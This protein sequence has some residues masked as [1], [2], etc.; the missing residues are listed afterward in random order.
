MHEC[1]CI[2]CGE[3][4]CFF[5][6]C[7]EHHA[8]ECVYGRQVLWTSAYTFAYTLAT[9][10]ASA[11]VYMQLVH[12]ALGNE[13]GGVQLVYESTC[14][15]AWGVIFDRRKDRDVVCVFSI[16]NAGGSVCGCVCVYTHTVT[17]TLRRWSTRLW[18]QESG[19]DTCR[20]GR[21]QID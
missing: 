21:I 15:L 8:C 6:R 9:G 19:W 1:I 5:D 13:D 2:F 3:C 14:C 11:L 16:L 20:D 12:S 18:A 7:C 10:C 4:A 17:H